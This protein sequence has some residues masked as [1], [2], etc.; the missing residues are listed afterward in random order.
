MVDVYTAGGR[1]DCRMYMPRGA[2]WDVASPIDA[3]AWASS[4][5]L[6]PEAKVGLYSGRKPLLTTAMLLFLAS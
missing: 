1:R 4:P 5:S 2:S 3:G 6:Y